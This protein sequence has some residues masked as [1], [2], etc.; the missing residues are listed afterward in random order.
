MFNARSGARNTAPLNRFPVFPLA[1][2]LLFITLLLG[3]FQ[4][5]STAD[6]TPWRQ[7]ALSGQT[8]GTSYHVKI[9]VADSETH[10]PEDLKEEIDQELA[11]DITDDVVVR[12]ARV[13]RGI[14]TTFRRDCHP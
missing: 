5:A 11:A 12:A 14:N 13:E 10:N 1:G 2:A 7:I 6:D 4:P 8:M 9:V 3:C